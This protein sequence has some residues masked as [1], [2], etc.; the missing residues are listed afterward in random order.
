MIRAQLL[1]L[2]F[3][4]V[5]SFLSAPAHAL[6][7]D[8]FET[9]ALQVQSG[10]GATTAAA[11]TALTGFRT[12]S[13]S[14]PGSAN[15][16]PTLT[17]GADNSGVLSYAPLP[18][19]IGSAG[20]VAWDAGVAFANGAPYQYFDLT[21]GGVSHTFAFDVLVASNLVGV[22]ANSWF[23]M[24][25][26]DAAGNTE[27]D[28]PLVYF[29]SPSF[30][31]EL[32]FGGFAT[33]HPNAASRVELHFGGNGQNAFLPFSIDNVRTIPEPGSGVLILGGFVGLALHRHRARGS[34][35]EA[36]DDPAPST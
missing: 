24:Q 18:G 7:I 11:S 36:P 13:S 20:S 6:L 19:H 2:L 1:R 12:L 33:S 17:A 31:V 3:T 16:A 21:D 9:P 29:D 23:E 10:A 32:P 30:P 25:Y 28:G 8:D 22:G 35:R 4:L 27:V 34:S 26:V 5:G 15:A 14:F